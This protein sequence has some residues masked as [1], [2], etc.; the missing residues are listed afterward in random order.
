[1][2]YLVKTLGEEKRL[3]FPQGARI[4]W[5]PLLV[6]STIGLSL[7]TSSRGLVSSCHPGGGGGAAAVVEPCVK[8]RGRREEVRLDKVQE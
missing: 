5:L 4:R 7:L 8:V 1:M 2:S 6:A 3:L